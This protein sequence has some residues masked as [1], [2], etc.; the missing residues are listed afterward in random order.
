MTISST[1]RKTQLNGNGVTTAFPWAFKVFSSADVVVI[2]TTSAGVD[3]TLV[4]DTDYSVSLNA[5]Q[6][7]SPGG[8]ITYPLSGSALPSGD[9]LTITSSVD[10]LQETDLTSG[11]G[12]YPQVIED[13]FDKAI[14]IIQ[15]LFERLSNTVRAPD[16]ETGVSFQLPT[17]TER[18]G[19]TLGFDSSGNVLALSAITGVVASAFMATVLD[20]TTAAAA[21]ATLGIDVLTSTNN[22]FTKAQRGAI[23]TLTDAATI[24]VDLSLANNF[25]VTLAGNRALGA[26]TNA[27]A[28][29]SGMIE[30]NQ[31]GTGSRTLSYNAF[32]KFAGGVTPTLTTTASAKDVLA[33]YVNDGA[34]SATCTIIKDVK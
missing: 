28:G 29:Q 33:Y 27:V 20:D 6:N 14:I 32:W 8:T 26:P 11:G 21:R 31:D 15:E 9:R 18:A 34:A 30:I 17:A 19:H 13:A 2:K 4:L 25:K 24:A 3:T 16:S 23:S 12:F 22:T 5:D 10:M 7:S 1:T